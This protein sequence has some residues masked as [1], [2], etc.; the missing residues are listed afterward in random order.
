MSVRLSAF[1]TNT[2][3]RDSNEPFRAKDGFSV[4]A[5]INRKVPSSTKG[6]KCILLRFIEPVHL[7]DEEHGAKTTLLPVS[8]GGLG[9]RT[10]VFDPCQ[11]RRD[12]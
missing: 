6:K 7:V 12:G 2:R 11:H 8:S 1:K 4:V 5:P 10:Y 9:R 3:A